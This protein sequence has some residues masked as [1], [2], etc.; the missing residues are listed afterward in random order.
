MAVVAV[1]G[2]S[3]EDGVR[4]GHSPFSFSSLPV[5][6]VFGRRAD[7]DGGRDDGAAA[8]G[9]RRSRGAVV[10]VVV[11][12]ERASWKGMWLTCTAAQLHPDISVIG[13]ELAKNDRWPSG[14][15]CQLK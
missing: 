12:E 7:D 4:T 10:V 15:K 2:G 3:E 14:L 5:V 1:S 8:R 13:H 11:K 6:S 9:R